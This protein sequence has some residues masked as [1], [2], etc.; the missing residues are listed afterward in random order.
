[1]R[2]TSTTQTRAVLSDIQV[3]PFVSVSVWAVGPAQI[4]CRDGVASKH[5]F[6]M[7]DSFK[8][9]RIYAF[10]NPAE[11]VDFAPFRDG[12]TKIQVGENVRSDVDVD[13]AIR[14]L[15][16]KEEWVAVADDIILT[17]LACNPFPTAS[18]TINFK[19]AQETLD[20]GLRRSK[21][22]AEY[23]TSMGPA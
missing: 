20:D 4:T 14:P 7:K 1:M 16:H 11:V 3:L 17:G 10:S 18:S 12:T 22:G 13:S 5:V 6:P 9:P 21:H 8:V 2:T 23:T 15:T 19:L